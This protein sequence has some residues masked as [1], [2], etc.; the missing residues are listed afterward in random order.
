MFIK[1]H[2]LSG[3]PVDAHYMSQ[4]QNL[5]HLGSLSILK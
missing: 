3:V 2:I 4:N 1:V 5:T